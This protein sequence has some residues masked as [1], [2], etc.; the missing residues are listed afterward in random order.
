MQEPFWPRAIILVDMNAFFAAVEQRDHP[1]WRGKPL[2]V[3][4]G[5]EGTCIITCSY[6]ARAYG[7]KTGMRLKQARQLCPQLIQVASHPYRYAEVSQCIMQALQ[8]VTPDIELFSIDEAFLDVTHCQRLYGA[9]EKIARMVQQIVIEAGKGLLCSI[10]VSGDKTTAKYAAKLRK[11]NGFTVIP[12]WEAR[13]CLENIP[14]TELCGVKQGIAGFLARYGAYT[15]GEVANLPV[16]LLAK[17]F[18]NLGRRIWLMSQGLDPDLVHTTVAAPKSM[19]HGKV[20]PPQT[21]QPRLLYTYLL[22]M[23]EKLAARLRRHHLQAQCFWISVYAP[24]LG[25]LGQKQR[26]AYPTQ[27]GLTIYQLGM[28]VLA[29]VWCGQAVN[30]IQVTA[31][32]PQPVN[33]QEDFFVKSQSKRLHKVIDQINQRYGEFTIMPAPLLHRSRMH[34]VIAPAWKPQGHRQSI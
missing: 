28:C 4:N 12:P 2:V 16:S 1:E 17:R 32:D 30:H 7:V 13:A 21:K 23:S 31:L 20:L 8:A 25:C 26:L 10:G 5:Q 3:T 29:R 22:H 14:V 15:C 19:G 11:P 9:P 33:L 34:N 18:G 27:D 24:Q 6:E